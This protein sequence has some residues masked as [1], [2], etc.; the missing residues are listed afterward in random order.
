MTWGM[1]RSIFGAQSTVDGSLTI[2][3]SAVHGVMDLHNRFQTPGQSH[4]T[5]VIEHVQATVPAIPPV[6]HWW[7]EVKLE[8]LLL[9]HTPVF[10]QK[11]F[12]ASPTWLLQGKIKN[13]H[14]GW[15]CKDRHVR[16]ALQEGSDN[17]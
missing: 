9:V 2:K 5:K 8:L 15:L 10:T 17:V 12:S 13:F 4:G 7:N 14:V 6:H 3:R 11:L 16:A 1:L